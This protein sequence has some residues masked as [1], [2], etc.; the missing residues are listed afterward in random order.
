VHLLC[1]LCRCSAN[2]RAVAAWRLCVRTY[3]DWHKKRQDEQSR[4]SCRFMGFDPRQYLGGTSR[5]AT[6]RRQSIRR[7][8]LPRS[9]LESDAQSQLSLI[10]PIRP[11]T[12]RA[13]WRLCPHS[14]T[15][16]SRTR[17]GEHSTRKRVAIPARV[18]AHPETVLHPSD[19]A[20]VTAS[21]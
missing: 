8:R 18:S 6:V 10:A 14:P 15:R 3:P 4:S 7:S 17:R 21:R 19:S 13:C 20:C 16:A 2:P 1:A 12:C 5:C 9:S 11:T